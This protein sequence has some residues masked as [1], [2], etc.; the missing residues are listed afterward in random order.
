M[1]RNIAIPTSI[2]LIVG[3]VA[4]AVL[5]KGDEPSESPTLASEDSKKPTAMVSPSGG[6]VSSTGVRSARPEATPTP[7]Q[8]KEGE[9]VKQYGRARTAQAR[10]V[11]EEVVSILDDV[12]ALGE[13]MM[14]GAQ[15]F[16]GGRRGMVGGITQRM[17]IELNDEQKDQAIALYEE[18]QQGQLEKS[19]NALNTLRND[20]TAMMSLFLAGD[21]VKRGDLDE[22]DYAAVRD[23]AAGDL[24]DVIN[25]LDRN[26]FRG[27][28]QM[29]N[30][31]DL[32]NRFAEI[33]DP[34]QADQFAAFREQQASSE[35]S[36]GSANNTNITAMPT[37]ELQTLE[38]AVGNAKKMTSGFR[39]V[40][41]GMGAMRD[42]GSQFNPGQ[43]QNPGE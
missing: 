19:K 2:L 26:S 42:L 10:E 15:Q 34:E 29:T 38:D 14:Q 13:M 37:M 27:D 17:G 22:A 24:V 5:K 30:D 7:R 43:N 20:P 39:Q 36:G 40:V 9:L 11:S 28:R 6:A 1:N 33:L 3:A 21:A 23:E 18:W 16:G 31:E 35:Q 25:P 8:S 12:V 32:M 4:I 41:E